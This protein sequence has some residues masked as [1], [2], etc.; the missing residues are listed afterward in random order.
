MAFGPKDGY[1][2]IGSGDR[3]ASSQ[4]RESANSPSCWALIDVE[5]DVKYDIPSDNPFT[6][7]DDYRDEIWALG[8][9]IRGGLHLIRR[10]LSISR[11]RGSY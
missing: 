2:Y 3:E 1:L 4:A 9:A 10:A 5:S 11:M 8:Y 6:Q 7:N